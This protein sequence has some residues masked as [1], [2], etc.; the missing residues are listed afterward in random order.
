MVLDETRRLA[1]VSATGD[2]G[3]IMQFDGNPTDAPAPVL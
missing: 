1:T 3:D 2:A